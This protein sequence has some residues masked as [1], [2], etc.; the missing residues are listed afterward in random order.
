MR[1]LRRGLK[2]AGMA[3]LAAAL[4][5][6]VAVVGWAY[7]VDALRPERGGPLVVTDVR[8]VVLRSVPSA[9]GRPGREAW[10]PLDRIPPAAIAV[11]LGSEDARFFAHVG[12]DPVGLL[13]AMWL[14]ARGMRAGYGGSTLTMQLVR[15]VD[16]SGERRTVWNKVRESVLALRLERA[17]AKRE[18]LEQYVN[19]AYY[20]NGAYGLE[21]AA[22]L[23]FAKPAAGLSVGEATLLA[24]LPRAPAACDPVRHLAEALARREHVLALLV[25]QGRMSAEAAARARAE[26]VAP[27]LHAPPFRA[28][29]FVDWVLAGLPAEVR[30]RGGVVRTTLDLALE[31][32]LEHRVEEH[33]AGLAGRDVRQAG[34][35]VLDTAS[36]AVR[37]M[38][39]SAGFDAA[40]GQVN[41]A[42]RRR[43]PGSALKPFIYALAVEAGDSP[44]SIAV[45]V[46]DVPSEY[47]VAKVT[48]PEHGPVR[49]REALAGSY[50]LAAVH[51]LEKVGVSRLLSKLREAGMGDLEGAADDYGLRMALGSARVRLVELAAAYGFLGRGGK[52]TRPVGVVEVE[53]ADG[54][55]WRPQRA[56]EVR[57]FSPQTSW[58][59]MDMLSDEEARHPVFGQEL[60]LEDLGFP[61]AAKT[62][63]S[64]GFADTVAVAVTRELTVAAWA[65][66]FDGQPTQGVI[67]MRAAAPLARTAILLA[68]RGRALTLPE[69]PSGIVSAT[70]CALSGKGVGAACPHTKVEQFVRGTEPRDVC[71]WHRAEGVRYPEEVARWAERRRQP[72]GGG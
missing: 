23:Y 67:A 33:V 9:D 13:R 30:A 69:R 20:G 53:F 29:H 63:T 42:T 52:V 16:S 25:E 28:A 61:V 4:A 27:T 49:Y 58:L 21:A 17:M 54:S 31:D 62:G 14:D 3:A 66:N 24:V 1:I 44:A 50:N 12:V 43:H 11:V 48:Q 36:G 37:A 26:P 57:L 51:V 35:V 68:A 45:D 65:G 47:R 5:L 70:V 59:V 8:G 22:E 10:V 19:R 32:E 15:M 2:W 39:G 34:V 46:A 7:P 72:R 64:R 40:T 56:E 18:I 71:D 6:G 55:S 38:V 60:P 41:I